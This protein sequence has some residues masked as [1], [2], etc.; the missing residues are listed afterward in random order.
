VSVGNIASSGTSNSFF[1]SGGTM[2]PG[3]PSYIERDADRELLDALLRSEFCYVL[4]TRQM[5]KSSLMA[6]AA[7]RLRG[8]C[9]V[10]TIDLTAFGQSLP[11]DHWYD[12]QLSAMGRQF[13]LEHEI[14]SFIDQHGELGP[15]D[16]W[17]QVIRDVIVEKAGKPVVIFVDEIDYV[18]ALPFPTDEFF[19]GIRHFYNARAVDPR[20]ARL[21]FC[22]LGVSTPNE[23]IR[24]IEVTPFNLGRRIVITDFKQRDAEKVLLP[25]LHSDPATA[26][27]ILQRV[28]FWTDGHPYLTQCVCQAIPQG[29]GPPGPE[30]VDEVCRNVFL[31]PGAR[32]RNINLQFV[33][34]RL[35]VPGSEADVL[36]LYAR[37]R[38]GG[39]VLDDGKQPF[40]ETLKLSGIAKAVDGEFRVRNEIYKQVFD[41]KWIDENMPDQEKRRVA[42]VARRVRRRAILIGLGVLIVLSALAFALYSEAHQRQLQ[43]ER[44]RSEAL[45]HEALDA[46]QNA[47]AAEK[48][49]K[50]DRDEAVRQTT[51]AEIAARAEAVQRVRA[52]QAEESAKI[53]AEAAEAGARKAA[54]AEAL[55]SSTAE[56]EKSA[57]QDADAALDKAEAATAALKNA[58]Q[59]LN[60]LRVQE[61]AAA[62]QR[63]AE[64]TL[65]AI[66]ARPPDWNPSKTVEDLRGLTEIARG[67]SGDLLPEVLSALARSF[68]L[69][70]LRSTQ[71][72]GGVPVILAMQARTWRLG[73][74][75]NFPNGY[76][77]IVHNAAANP[78]H[79]GDAVLGG[80][81]G[82][83]TF[84]YESPTFSW[85]RHFFPITGVGYSTDGEWIASASASGD[86]RLVRSSEVSA[87][88]GATSVSI[89]TRL[90]DIFFLAANSTKLIGYLLGYR[91]K[92][93]YPVV[94]FALSLPLDA[95]QRKVKR[96]EVTVYGLT[97]EGRVVTWK[98]PGP[99]G[100]QIASVDHPVRS[101]KSTV[102]TSDYT[103]IATEP[104]TQRVWLGGADGYL[105][106][107]QGNSCTELGRS[108]RRISAL[109]WNANSTRLAVGSSLGSV[110]VYNRRGSLDCDLTFL[111]EIPAHTA[112]VTS[113]VWQGDL[114]S[115]G[116]SDGSAR[117]W[118]LAFD[119]R[120][121]TILKDLQTAQ[122]LGTMIPR[123]N[124]LV[125]LTAD[126]IS[127][128]DSL[129]GSEQKPAS[130]PK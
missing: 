85:K 128:I 76:D 114:L 95:E 5:G 118:D 39:T 30:A 86:M 3:A 113:I 98:N 14:D 71:P 45:T 72:G 68:A 112:S 111:I 51:L 78:A 87:P 62:K 107:L 121:L 20:L 108:G 28:F 120:R 75:A 52:E 61:A 38:G 56:K 97:Q 84:E 103:A 65:E 1:V 60:A 32:E 54:A 129:F 55:A 15:L 96:K 102:R 18:R 4:D 101:Q 74:N 105:E 29:A 88:P 99:F 127:K 94:D 41:Q 43:A 63:E 106:V 16:R 12:A 57:R 93:D 13:H 48:Q 83:M 49:A 42:Q 117:T 126:V 26:R 6:R 92:G 82:W 34:N 73:D 35:L 36:S 122:S 17:I 89:S 11:L 81:G 59:Q 80:T 40:A 77:G 104:S 66:L 37:V 2:P 22:L 53:E 110:Q 79:P 7:S 130:K 47:L 115:T 9:A 119:D 31:L 50:A 109:A 116:S 100:T 8:Q 64:K 123:D 58:N 90:K 67:Y 124:Y 69:T 125:S 91:Y 33:A 24:S 44:D 70:T 10:A 46:E 25:G 21:T 23:L 19:A 27:K